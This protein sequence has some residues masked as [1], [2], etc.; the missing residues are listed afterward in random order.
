VQTGGLRA[1]VGRRDP[2]QDVI[3]VR[4]GVFD[5]DIEVFVLIEQ[6]G[7]RRHPGIR[8]DADAPADWAW[9]LTK[10]VARMT[11]TPK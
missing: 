2:Q 6:P 7:V 3:D 10:P 5:L 1:P 4:L 11:V 9:D 8:G